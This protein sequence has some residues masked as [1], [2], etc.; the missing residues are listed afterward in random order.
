MQVVRIHQQGGPEVLRL[1]EVPTPEPGPGQARV[2]VAA[3]GV[4][5]IDIYHRSGQY[6]VPLPFSIGREGAGTVEAVGPGVSDVGVGQRVAW[7]GVPG[8]YA[9]HVLAPAAELVPVPDGVSDQH[10]AA[11]MLQGMTAHY[12]SHSSFPLEAGTSC[13]IHAAAGGVGLLLCQMAKMRGASPIIGTTSTDA[14][15]RLAREAGADEVILYT[16]Q[17]FE[18]EVKRITGGRGVDVVYDS[19]GRDTFDKSLNCLRPRGYQVQFGASSGPVPPVNVERLMSGGSLYL[20][21]P[22]L[23]N[24]TATRQEL[25]QRAGDVFTWIREDKLRLRIDRTYPLEDAASAQADLASRQTTGK[26]LLTTG[27]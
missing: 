27:R 10:A 16:Q 20:T 12:L 11:A 17:D 22:T 15:A 3:A 18:A 4:N 26:L 23:A 5:F 24:Y 7:A 19:V 25:L 6:K 13:L 1:E 9:T 2:R 8:S 21:R 14:K